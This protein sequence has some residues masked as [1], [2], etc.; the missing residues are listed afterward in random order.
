M[1]PNHD[2]V[3]NP[4]GRKQKKLGEWYKQTGKLKDTKISDS[5]QLRSD[6][7]NL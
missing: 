1:Y 5:E 4:I 7:R 3:R 2:Q 6:A